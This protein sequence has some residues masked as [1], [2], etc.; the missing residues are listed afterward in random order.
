MKVSP[1]PQLRGASK[2]AY[3]FQEKVNN[4]I[5]FLLKR[6]VITPPRNAMNQFT[7]RVLYFNVFLVYWR[8][9][10]F[11]LFA[12]RFFFRSLVTFNDVI[13]RHGYVTCSSLDTPARFAPVK[14]NYSDTASVRVR[15]HDTA[16]ATGATVQDGRRENGRPLGKNWFIARGSYCNRRRFARLTGAHVRHGEW[17]DSRPRSKN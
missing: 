3:T 11:R 14:K 16:N 15:G 13:G 5:F 1:L 4:T 9:N 7:F 6:R 8:E 17:F 2:I 10:V 12:W